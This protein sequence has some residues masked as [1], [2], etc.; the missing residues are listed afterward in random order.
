MNIDNN[1]GCTYNR[2]TNAGHFQWNIEKSKVNLQKHGVSFE[3]AVT[4]FDDQS[5]LYITDTAHSDSEQRYLVIG[6]SEKLNILVV[7]HCI[8]G[9]DD[10]IRIISARKAEKVE[11]S[12]Y[13]RYSNKT[14]GKRFK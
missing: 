11:I 4:A 13:E 10:I 1:T 5:A 2:C 3:E 8:R 14:S 6:M 7:S 12:I 9:N